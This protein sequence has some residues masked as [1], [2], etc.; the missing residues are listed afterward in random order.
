[1]E[2]SGKDVAFE[3]RGARQTATLIVQVV[4]T[5]V[6][7]RVLARD[8]RKLDFR[9]SVDRRE[10]IGASRTRSVSSLDLK[11]GTYRIRAGVIDDQAHHFG[12]VAGDLDVPDYAKSRLA[13]SGILLASRSTAHVPTLRDNAALFETRLPSPP[14]TQRAFDSD[15]GAELYAEAYGPLPG[16]PVD[17][18]VSILDS[19]GRLLSEEPRRIASQSR[20]L[21]GRLC[22]PIRAPL[23]LDRLQRGYYVVQ[24]TTR[25]S[26]AAEATRRLAFE[27]R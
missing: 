2:I 7:G 15:G 23:R 27:I 8:S 5:D 6:A 21:A 25:A 1:L 20:G 26:G 14:T 18:T 17:A 19:A 3:Q 12:V 16:E 4:A 11:P 13:L 10:Q 22:Y 9:V 24:L